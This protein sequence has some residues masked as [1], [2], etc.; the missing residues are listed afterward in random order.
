MAYDNNPIQQFY[1]TAQN[2][3]F[4]R[5]FQF[6]LRKFANIAFDPSH[7]VYVE[8]AT[9]PGRSITNIPVTYMGMDFNTPGTVKYPG[10]TS[11][12]VTF[13]CDAS[14]NIRR[15]LEVA[16]FDL[17]DE[18]TSQGSYGIPGTETTVVLELFD[19]RMNPVRFYT[20]FGAWVQAIG[21]TQYDVKDTGTVQTVQCTLAYQFWRASQSFDNTNAIPE[22]KPD[23]PALREN[24]ITAGGVF[25]P[26]FAAK[27]LRHNV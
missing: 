8:S 7:Y 16:T 12:Q 11:Y 19:K 20:L 24:D 9:V 23:Q 13:R 17:F 18:G 26:T 2:R 5:L 22:L 3:D 14:Y 6:R 10:S 15:A 27:D 21:D 4:A 25:V 1:S